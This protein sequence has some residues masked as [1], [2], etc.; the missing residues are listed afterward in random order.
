MNARNPESLDSP[1][2]ELGEFFALP[3]A[4]GD[5][6]LPIATLLNDAATMREYTRRARSAIAASMRVGVA[7]VPVKAAASSVHLSIVARLLSPVV[8]AAT[9]L[10]TFPLLTAKTLFWQRTS[11]HRP[12]LGAAGA[13]CATVIGPR[14]SADAIADSVVHNVLRP[15]NETMRLAA[16]LSPRVLWG[17]V[18][19]AA[20]GAVT[21]L[22][23]SRPGDEPRGRALVAA[24][25]ATDQLREA[26]QIH[27]GQFLRRNCCLFYQVPGAGYCG[28]CVLLSVDRRT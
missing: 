17:N 14:Q 27:D 23:L 4:D 25:I 22:A 2:A 19:S 13:M 18:A 24:L 3:V 15:L 12:A 21:V 1:V 26:A 16:A 8:G 7:D 28:D 20:N 6:W 5:S 10:P 11:S 9:C